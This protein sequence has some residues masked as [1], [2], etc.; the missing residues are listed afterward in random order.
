MTVTEFKNEFNIA[1]DSIASNMAPALDDY[2]ISVFLTRAQEQLVKN[3]FDQDSNAKRRGFENSSKRRWDLKELIKNYKSMN[4]VVLTDKGIDPRSKFY[5]IPSDVF[6]IVNEQ[7]V[8]LDSSC[9]NAQKTVS[10]DPKTHDEY[11]DQKDNP[12]KKPYNKKVWRMDYNSSAGNNVVELISNDTI[13]S[14]NLRYIKKPAPIIISD[15]SS[16]GEG[17][18]IEGLFTPR[19]SELDSTVHSEIV[20]RA[21]ELAIAS[22][23]QNNLETKITVDSRNE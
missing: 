15:L 16:F 7:A 12:F 11:N 1:Y 23:R 21:V 17:L 8:I 19:T 10:V 22:Y 18:T 5:A 2:E 14:Y 4:E 6:L 9:N 20:D 13:K 3:K